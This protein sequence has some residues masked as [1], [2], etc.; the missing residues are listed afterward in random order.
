MGGVQA[1]LREVGR[2][3]EVGR[4]R[5]PIVPGAILFDLGNGGDKMW[6]RM[7]PYWDLG[8]AS[9][10]TAALEF[11][12]GNVGAGLGVGGIG[13]APNRS[14]TSFAWAA[15][16]GISYDITQN[17]KLDVGYR[18]LDMGDAQSAAIACTVPSACEKQHYHLASNDIRIGLRW[19]INDDVPAPPPEAP[20][21]RK[22]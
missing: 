18:Y 5:I 1:A 2:G 9:A 12:L 13:F 16:A 21:I 7:P 19:M 15:M 22:D 10:K 11:P 6:A 3:V 14:V 8:Y 4:F 17:L 20:I